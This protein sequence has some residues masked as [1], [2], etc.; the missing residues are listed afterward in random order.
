[1]SQTSIIASALRTIELEQ[2]SVA[3][4]KAFI[5]EDFVKATTAI[6]AAKGR[7]VIS[8]HWQ[9]C[10]HRTKNFGYP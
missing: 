3:G 4:L 8:R 5:N 10:H 2:A 7:L 6:L 9:K 1:M